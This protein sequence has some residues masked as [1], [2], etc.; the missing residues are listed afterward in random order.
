MAGRGDEV[1][2]PVRKVRVHKLRPPSKSAPTDTEGQPSQAER[3]ADVER[4][5]A[6]LIPGIAELSVSN[7]A[8][9]NAQRGA[10]E[11]RQRMQDRE[12]ALRE[13]VKELQTVYD[14][15]VPHPVD[16][17][18]SSAQNWSQTLR[19][20]PK[21]IQ[22]SHYQLE[23]INYQ[24]MLLRKNIWYYRDRMNISRGP[25]PLHML[26]SAWVQGVIDENTLV[27]GQGLFD[28]LPAKNVKLLLPMVRTPEVRFGAWMK[29]TFALK[30]ALNR[31]REQRKDFRDPEQLTKQVE[32]MR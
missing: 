3:D 18:T 12:A 2:V 23:M 15:S 11:V 6:E 32:W 16:F 27:W 28:W 21:R 5:I 25:C 31:I 24:R 4:R 26:K 22:L 10:A 9:A 19:P 29:R 13:E 8:Q 30:P 1:P 14:M 17:Q 7:A 20:P